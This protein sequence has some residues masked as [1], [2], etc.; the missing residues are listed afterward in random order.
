MD[1]KIEMQWR[2]QYEKYVVENYNEKSLQLDSN[3]NYF[4]MAIRNGWHVWLAAK[5]AQNPIELPKPFLMDDTDGNGRGEYLMLEMVENRLE[6]SG[7]KYT[8][9]KG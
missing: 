5:R 4:Y 2:Q 9:N 7:I 6:K 1:S 8:V 3:G